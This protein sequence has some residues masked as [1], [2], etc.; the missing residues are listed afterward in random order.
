MQSRTFEKKLAPTFVL[1]CIGK[2]YSHNKPSSGNPVYRT[3]SPGGTDHPGNRTT[4]VS[5]PLLH[6]EGLC[7]AVRYDGGRLHPPAPA[8]RR[9]AGGPHNGPEYHRY[10]AVVQL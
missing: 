1:L 6:S 8:L 5:V 7:H 10:R 2:S 3:A 9:R 4:G